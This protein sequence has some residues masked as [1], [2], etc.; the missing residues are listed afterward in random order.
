MALRSKSVPITEYRFPAGL[1]DQRKPAQ[2]HFQPCRCQVIGPAAYWRPPNHGASITS[3]ELASKR[4]VE[5]LADQ[6]EWR[7]IDS[8]SSLVL[9]A[10]LDLKR[11]PGFVHPSAIT[12]KVNA[13]GVNAGKSAPWLLREDFP[14]QISWAGLRSLLRAGIAEN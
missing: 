10:W 7:Q 6:S 12:H 1:E 3:H 11:I 9:S 13:A 2:G 4:I 5:R 14:L 8:V